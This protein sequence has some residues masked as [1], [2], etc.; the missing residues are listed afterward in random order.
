[1]N[2][3]IC[4]VEVREPLNDKIINF[5][6]AFSPLE[7]QH[8]ILRQRVKRTADTMVVGGALVR[9][10]LWRQF[11]ILPDTQICYGKFGKPYLPDYPHAHFNVSHSGQYVVCAVCDAPIGIDIQR[12]VP[13][14]PDVA[15][16]VFTTAELK[17]IECSSDSSIEFTKIWT[18]M[19]A[20]AKVSGM[21]IGR[22]P[23]LDIFSSYETVSYF[24]GDA[25]VSL[26]YRK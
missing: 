13:Y 19:E 8:R 14:R 9:H 18:Q 11:S 25:F 21:G 4:L 24:V 15:V 10:M 5:L 7:K 16:R 1:M 26:S 6:L 12:V 2:P 23:D 3:A 22:K 17:Q 20:R